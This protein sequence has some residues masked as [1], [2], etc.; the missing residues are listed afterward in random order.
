MVKS[1]DYYLSVSDI[2]AIT[3]VIR[4]LSN[5]IQ[6]GVIHSSIHNNW[7]SYYRMAQ[8]SFTRMRAGVESS[9]D[10]VEG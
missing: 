3:D 2:D 1:K 8:S 4:H 10:I 7:A 9:C 6:Y 5:V